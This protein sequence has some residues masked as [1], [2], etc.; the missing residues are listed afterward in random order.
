[1]LELDLN[2]GSESGQEIPT[3]DQSLP[4]RSARERRPIDF[5]GAERAIL[6]THQ[7]PIVPYSSKFS[8]SNNFLIFVRCIL[9]AKF[10]STKM[11][12]SMGVSIGAAM[13]HKVL[14]VRSCAG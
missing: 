13:N 9:I 1:M 6:T 10:L 12:T 3:H 5:Y 14:S 7:K 8:R 2:E 11:F 4:M